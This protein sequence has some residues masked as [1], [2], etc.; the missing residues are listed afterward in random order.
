MTNILVVA[1]IKQGELKGSTA[2]LLSKAR[3]LGADTA[4]VAVGS[5]V[6]DLAEQL[7]A[8]GSDTQYI[9]EDASLEIFSAK[10]FAAAVVKAAN[11]FNADMVW[12]GFSETGKAAAPR[13]AVQL[14]AA[15]ATEII[16][17]TIDGDAVQIIRPAIANKVLQ[18]L[19][20]NA[21]KLV[22]VVRAGA[23]EADPGI[24]GKENVVALDVPE[25]DTGA[26]VKE[27]ISDASG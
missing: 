7:A 15:C 25:A 17:V 11:E 23:F 5:Q 13:V 1:D 18:K 16:D 24:T 20:V 12:F 4:V 27:L 19:K 21:P 22:A 2:E 8:A 26:R 14:E 6:K 10:P 9:V 3:A